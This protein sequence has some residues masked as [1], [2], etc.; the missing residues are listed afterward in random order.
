MLHD[1]GEFAATDADGTRYVL[2][3][4]TDDGGDVTVE[5]ADGK[6]VKRVEKGHYHLG[7][8]HQTVELTSDDPNAP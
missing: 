4:W 1:R 3:S 6:P 8:R 5:T 7:R 2:R